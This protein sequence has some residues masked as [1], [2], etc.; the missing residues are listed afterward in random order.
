MG[1]FEE[2][3]LGPAAAVG[4]RVDLRPPAAGEG[5]H[6]PPPGRELRQA[7]RL[8]VRLAQA[9]V[10][11]GGVGRPVRGS[12][13]H[14]VDPVAPG[15]LAGR[16]VHGDQRDPGVQQPLGVG[17]HEVQVVVRVRGH[18]EEQ[19]PPCARGGDRLPGGRIDGRRGPAGF[20][21]GA[22]G[23]GRGDGEGGGE[24]RPATGCSGH[25]RGPSLGF[26]V[27]S[28]RRISGCRGCVR[29]GSGL[30]GVGRR[31][32]CLEDR[33]RGCRG[34]VLGTDRRVTARRRGARDRGTPR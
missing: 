17:V 27:S 25:V 24:H 2:D 13:G 16:H 12:L 32:E 8:R 23:D 18:L 22:P 9:L 15:V 29:I 3:Q 30:R 6:L 5:E 1:R 19:G 20:R 11:R 34:R 21:Y 26:S 31:R 4:E 33:R 10:A 28:A 14:P 7:E